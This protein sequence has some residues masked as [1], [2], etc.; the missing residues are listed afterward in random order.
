[1]TDWAIRLAAIPTRV[2][3][4]RRHPLP[5]AELRRVGLQIGVVAFCSVGV[6]IAGMVRDIVIASK[7]GTSDA[8]DAFI[9]AW[10]VPQFL[11]LIIG[12]AFAGAVIPLYADAKRNGGAE[13]ASR[14][15]SELV[16]V[17]TAITAVLTLLLIPARGPL[18]RLVT[19]SFGPSKLAVTDSLWMLMLPAVF[20]YAMTTLWGAILN[21]KDQFA[22][23]AIS[24][25]V[26]PFATIIPLI[27]YPQ[28]GVKSPAV[29]FVVGNLIQ[30]IWLLWGLHRSGLT[31]W[32][33]WF[34]GLSET[35]GALGQVLP[36]LANGIVFGGIPVVD[37]ALAATLG[38]GNLAIL[39]YGNKL[40]LPVLSIGSSAL[41]TV[42]YPRFARLVAEEDWTRLQRQVRG[43]LA[44]TLAVTIPTMLVLVFSSGLIVRLVFEHGAFDSRDT[45]SVANVQAIFAL[46]IP[47]YT[48]SQLLSRVINAM[49]AVRLLVIG[50]TA[51]F[52]INVTGDWL[53]KHW[54][55]INGIAL[56]TVL[57]FMLM[58]VFNGYL[59]RRLIGERLRSAPVTP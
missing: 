55:G 59:F 42:V 19:T 22:L 30:A 35:R 50:S 26:I 57:N 39:N 34:G 20:L 1:L 10:I 36:Y 14:F 3:Q 17:S 38:N 54:F 32:P 45:Q 27:V 16:L 49:R 25:L 46:M 40:V 2:R 53:F 21:T 44:L 11:A 28:G 33:R 47:A 56:A 8:A 5:L 9:A 37:Q 48:L 51:V 23:A 41:A 7:F 52:V 13:R 15:L 58:L 18:L 12:N 4:Q 24:P 6:K 43:Y 29:G 31:C